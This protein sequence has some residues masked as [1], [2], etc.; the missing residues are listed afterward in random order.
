MAFLTGRQAASLL[1]LWHCGLLALSL[2]S[3]IP[4]RAL[5]N[6]S[7]LS[8]SEFRKRIPQCHESSIHAGL[9]A[10]LVRGLVAFRGARSVTNRLIR[11]RK[12]QG[13]CQIV[14]NGDRKGVTKNFGVP[15]ANGRRDGTTDGR[16]RVPKRF[17]TTPPA[18]TGRAARMPLQQ[19]VKGRSWRLFANARVRGAGRARTR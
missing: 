16:A 5:L 1:D 14:R 6:V 10:G 19:A 11:H 12:G 15:C 17:L 4:C 9:R 13:R 8:F 7:F 3:P 18:G 2:S